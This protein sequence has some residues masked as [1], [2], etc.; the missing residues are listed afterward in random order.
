MN[1]SKYFEDKVAAILSN[2]FSLT[3]VGTKPL[4]QVE[5][6]IENKVLDSMD[7]VWSV[8]NSL[9]PYNIFMSDNS[10]TIKVWDYGKEK[11]Q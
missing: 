7:Q 2:K 10:V 6:I 11:V 1:Y 9:D 3:I 8:I 4:T 5:T